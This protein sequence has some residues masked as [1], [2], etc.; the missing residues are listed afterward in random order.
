MTELVD[1]H[2]H[3][4]SRLVPKTFSLY[5]L[6]ADRKDRSPGADLVPVAEAARARVFSIFFVFNID[7][8]SH[9]TSDALSISASQ[10]PS[11]QNELLPLR[12]GSTARSRRG[13]FSSRAT[14][15]VAST[16]EYDLF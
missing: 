10:P 9:H 5:S 2:H 15:T 16:Y 13:S 4:L 1:L 7:R 14:A 8:H 3:Q 11:F 12:S 6:F